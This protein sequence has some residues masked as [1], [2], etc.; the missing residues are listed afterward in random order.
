MRHQPQALGHGSEASQSREKSRTPERRQKNS[1]QVETTGPTTG[2]FGNNGG[3]DLVVPHTRG[4]GRKTAHAL[5]A[6][7]EC[8]DRSQV[9]GEFAL[10]H[11]VDDRDS[12][13][14]AVHVEPRHSVCRTMWKTQA[15]RHAADKCIFTHGCEWQ[16]VVFRLGVHTRFHFSDSSGLRLLSGSK[17]DLS[18]LQISK[19][20]PESTG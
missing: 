17:E 11:R 9:E 3:D 7:V 8:L 4:A 12:P 19:P 6:R 15:A 18:L 16:R 14:R 1:L 10:F 5:D 13:P 2:E 20:G